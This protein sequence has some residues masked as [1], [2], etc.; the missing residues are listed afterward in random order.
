MTQAMKMLPL[1]A[2]SRVLSLY[3]LTVVAA[4]GAPPMSTTAIGS[5]PAISPGLKSLRKPLTTTALDFWI[6]GA[7]SP[8]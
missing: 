7:K 1:C 2:V 3:A 4:A 5:L 6:L 8:V